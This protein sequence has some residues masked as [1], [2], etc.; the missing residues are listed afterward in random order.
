MK[1]N[2]K[3]NQGTGAAIDILTDD[4]TDRSLSSDKKNCFSK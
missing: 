4:R 1:D 3:M 2:S